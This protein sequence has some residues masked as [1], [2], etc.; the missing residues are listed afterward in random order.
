MKVKVLGNWQPSSYDYG[1]V[2]SEFRE[3]LRKLLGTVYRD[4]VRDPAYHVDPAQI[5]FEWHQD[6]FGENTPTVIWSNIHPTEIRLKGNGELVSPQPGDIVWFDNRAVE[7][8]APEAARGSDRW[9]IRVR[10]ENNP[11]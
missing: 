10:T 4:H 1:T 6:N 7:H 2:A 11:S 9:F 3:Q 5:V 8:R